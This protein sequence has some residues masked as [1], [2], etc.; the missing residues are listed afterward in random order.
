MRKRASRERRVSILGALWHGHFAR[1]RLGPRRGTDR[2]PVMTDWFQ[3]Q[4]LVTAILIL[5]LSTI[6]A[7]LTLELVSRGAAEMNPF[8]EPLIRG[9]GHGFAFWKV[10]LTAM[11]VVVLTMLA[12]FRILGGIAVGSV[13]YAVLC[14]YL[15]LVGYELWLLRVLPA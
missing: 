1:R 13:L 10:G 2:H 11:G 7:M 6:D 5:V 3:P 9:S 4:W 15:A 14:G 12:R 8:M